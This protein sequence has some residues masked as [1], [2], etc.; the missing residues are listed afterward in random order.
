MSHEPRT[1]EP[2]KAPDCGAE[3]V[4]APIRLQV[5]VYGHWVPR[6][7]VNTAQVGAARHAPQ[8]A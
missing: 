6:T 1:G 7:A 5:M 2:E 3:P 4:M 8:Q